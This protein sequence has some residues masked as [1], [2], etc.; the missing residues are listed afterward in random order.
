[1]KLMIVKIQSLTQILHHVIIS[2]R[3]NS[4]ELFIHTLGASLGAE[5][6]MISSAHFRTKPFEKSIAPLLC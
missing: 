4:F 2:Q 1:M 5:F 6:Q 3:Y